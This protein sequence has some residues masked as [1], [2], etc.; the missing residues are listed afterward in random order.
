MKLGVLGASGRMGQ[1]II[2]YAESF[3]FEVSHAFVSEQSQ[4][5]GQSVAGTHYRHLAEAD[6]AP[7][8]LI[9]F[10]LPHALH[11]NLAYAEAHQC[12]IVVCTTGLDAE[13]Q[14][15]LRD[16]A[17]QVPTLHARNTSLG[18]ALMEQLTRI[19]AG[20]F[21]EADIEIFEAHHRHKKDGPSGTALALGEAAARGRQVQFEAINDGVRGDGER[22]AHGIGFSVVRAADI[23][24]EHQVWLAQAGERIELSHRVSDRRIFAEGALRA[25]NW[26]TAQTP[27]ECYQM[28]DVLD[29]K[30]QLAQLLD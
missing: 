23:V 24:G 30:K 29:L 6:D 18:V 5:L 22:S 2:Q 9:D 25:A 16:T 15:R 8:V 13:Q 28:A 27:G 21:K 20:A 3:G 12:P 26:L 19:A 11:E 14:Q 1:Q 10:S 4:F 17:S 7:D